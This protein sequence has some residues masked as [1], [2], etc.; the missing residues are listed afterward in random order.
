MVWK[1]YLEV[2]EAYNIHFPPSEFGMRK[3]GQSAR[4]RSFS[5]SACSAE[6]FGGGGGR[7]AG[8]K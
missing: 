2:F 5:M 4:P 8:K 6:R 1:E 7:A 3:S